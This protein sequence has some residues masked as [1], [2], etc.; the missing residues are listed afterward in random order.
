MGGRRRHPQ[1]IVEII[2]LPGW[3]YAASSPPLPGVHPVAAAGACQSPCHSARRRRCMCKA[4]Q[5]VAV[6]SGRR[7]DASANAPAARQPPRRL[8]HRTL[9]CG[10][11]AAGVSCACRRR[12]QLMAAACARRSDISVSASSPEYRLGGTAPAAPTRTSSTSAPSRRSHH[13]RLPSSAAGCQSSACRSWGS[14]QGL[15][16]GNGK[17]DVSC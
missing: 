7:S 5:L 12:P 11:C 6:A 9:C 2:S 4:L 10:A 13:R 1:T 15:Q 17:S 14:Q 8:L 3:L 16:H